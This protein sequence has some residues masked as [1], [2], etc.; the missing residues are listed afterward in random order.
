MLPV[1]DLVSW[2]DAIPRK[3]SFCQENAVLVVVYWLCVTAAMPVV[4][5]LTLQF[6]TSVF[7][8]FFQALLRWYV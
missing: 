8:F 2:H 1:E 5:G 6:A 3:R 4:F 7:F